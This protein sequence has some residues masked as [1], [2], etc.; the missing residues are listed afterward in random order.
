MC[1]AE[2]NVYSKLEAVRVDRQDRR[3]APG[4]KLRSEAGFAARSVHQSD[5]D[6]DFAQYALA[7][8]F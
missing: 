4:D 8:R 5:K 6:A 7:G 2:F 3:L 1:L